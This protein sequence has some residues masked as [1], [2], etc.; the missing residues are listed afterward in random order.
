MWQVEVA[1]GK[2]VTR[3]TTPLIFQDSCGEKKA[4][5]GI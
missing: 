2:D 1:T 3:L 5:I 4:L